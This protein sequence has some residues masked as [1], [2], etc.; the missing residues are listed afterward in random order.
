MFIFLNV[1]ILCSESLWVGW[2]SYPASLSQIELGI[3][4]FQMLWVAR[5]TAFILLI[6]TALIAGKII[7]EGEKYYW[8]YIGIVPAFTLIWLSYPL[9]ALRVFISVIVFF[10][11]NKSLTNRLF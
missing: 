10:F 11:I 7:R 3:V 2:T 1:L 5:I 4:N 6:L 8:L 9:D